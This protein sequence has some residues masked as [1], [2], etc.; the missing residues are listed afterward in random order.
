[1]K[2]SILAASPWRFVIAPLGG[3]AHVREI[4]A[5]KTLICKVTT[6]NLQAAQA[7]WAAQLIAAAPD[8]LKL[9]QELVGATVDESWESD[10]TWLLEAARAAI[11][12]ATGAS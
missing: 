8:L 6:Q 7:D 3:K 10:R 2:T 12:K 9:A 5:G 1:M 4:W 11:L